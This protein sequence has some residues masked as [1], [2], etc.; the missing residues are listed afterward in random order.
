MRAV[1]RRSQTRESNGDSN[2]VRCRPR[3][4]PASRASGWAQARSR[5]PATV[6]ATKP[7]SSM[8]GAMSVRLQPVVVGEVG[9]RGH[10]ERAR[11]ES[12]ELTP[13]RVVVEIDGPQGSAGST[14]SGRS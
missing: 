4:R 6:T 8:S 13:A 7:H 14:R 1:R 3:G 11:R 5:Q 12:N 2:V 10:T 9:Q